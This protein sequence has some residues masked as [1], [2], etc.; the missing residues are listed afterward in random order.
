M[1]PLD[2]SGM[3]MQFVRSV[4][5]AIKS[6]LFSVFPVRIQ[7]GRPGVFQVFWFCM[8]LS[9]AVCSIYA[10]ATRWRHQM[11]SNLIYE[12]L[13]ATAAFIWF[14]GIHK[15]Q[16]CT[17]KYFSMFFKSKEKE[18]KKQHPEVAIKKLPNKMKCHNHIN[19]FML[20][21]SSFS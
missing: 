6:K 20:F 19:C 4:I 3:A 2:A 10:N 8:H 11:Q 15:P 5:P 12:L 1:D 16:N 21:T 14:L 13:V 7:R 18:Q 17:D 9:F